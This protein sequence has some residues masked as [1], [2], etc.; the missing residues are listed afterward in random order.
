MKYRPL[1]K[2]QYLQELFNVDENGNVYW[3]INKGKRGIAGN[4]AGYERED[5]LIVQ[6]DNYKWFLHRILFVIYNGDIDITNFD[7]DHI[8]G[9]TKNN[10][11]NNLR[12]AEHYRNNQNQKTP[13]NNTSGC[14]GVTW[15]KQQGKWQVRIAIAKKMIT[16]GHFSNYIYACLVRKR[17]EKKYYG[18]WRCN[19]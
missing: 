1:P 19:R 2:R 5:Y 3:K 6:I 16:I 4:I 8:D 18:E 7:I 14:K 13:K 10:K 17:A 15:R 9:N 12:M 11:K